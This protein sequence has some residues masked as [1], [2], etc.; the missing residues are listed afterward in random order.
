MIKTKC[1]HDNPRKEDGTRICI[2]R[3]IRP[4]YRF[5][6]WIIELSPSEF[7][8]SLY[9][10][11]QIDWDSFEKMYINEMKSPDKIIII[12]NLKNRSFKG[13]TITLLCCEHDDS[14]CHRRLLKDIINNG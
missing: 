7:L 6:E 10:K 3:Y 9:R 2:M 12:D 14:K 4:S 11:S 1:I 13:E 8:L 5:D